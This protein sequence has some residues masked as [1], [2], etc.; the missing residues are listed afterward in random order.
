MSDDG[1]EEFPTFQGTCICEHEPEQHGWGI[2]DVEVYNAT[3]TTSTEQYEIQ[4]TCLCQAG[5][6]E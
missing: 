5:W 4:L 6:E 2:C 3:L 1:W